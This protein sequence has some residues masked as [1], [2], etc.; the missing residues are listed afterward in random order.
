MCSASDG[1]ARIWNP[2]SGGQRYLINLTI[3]EFLRAQFSIYIHVIY[4]QGTIYLFQRHIIKRLAIDLLEYQAQ[5]CG[6]LASLMIKQFT[7][8]L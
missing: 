7:S 5:S 8:K 6:I 2:V 1:R 3:H 4:V